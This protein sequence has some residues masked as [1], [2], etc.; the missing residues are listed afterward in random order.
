MQ[1]RFSSL[2]QY[3]PTLTFN[4]VKSSVVFFPM[5][6]QEGAAYYLGQPAGVALPSLYRNTQPLVEGVEG[7]DFQFGLEGSANYKWL[8]QMVN[9]DWEKVQSVRFH[10]LVASSQPNIT[11]IPQILPAPFN[12]VSARQ[13]CYPS[14]AQ[15]SRRVDTGDRRLYRVFVGTAGIRNAGAM[16]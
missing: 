1:N 11:E 16:L 15:C 4:S 2:P 10:I 14:R 13:Y 12:N 8:S 7:L 6:D 5:S 9:S 3:A